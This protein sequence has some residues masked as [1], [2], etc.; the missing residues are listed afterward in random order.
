VTIVRLPV[1]GLAAAACAAASDGTAEAMAAR[2]NRAFFILRVLRWS[3]WDVEYVRDVEYVHARMPSQSTSRA[4][5]RC[6][7]MRRLDRGRDGS[8][9]PPVPRW[10]T[11]AV[12]SCS[13]SVL[14]VHC[15]R[16]AIDRRC[17]AERP[18]RRA[19]GAPTPVLDCPGTGGQGMDRQQAFLSDVQK[20]IAELFRSS[21]AA[22]LERNVKATLAQ[23]FQ[24]MDLVTREEFD[25]Q[26]ET[27]ARLRQR[28]EALEARLAERPR[29]G[30]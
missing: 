21:P 1:S 3:L 29:D 28:L 22:D 8:R 13:F 14:R 2:A 15:R 6:T 7:T 30:A 25:I 17:S 5:R 24:R 9:A 12:R 16:R 4:I 19:L 27:V 23:T 26:V 18:G 20:R 11:T 10:C